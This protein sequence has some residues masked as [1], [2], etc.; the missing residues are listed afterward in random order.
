DAIDGSP[1]LDLKPWVMEFGPR[2]PLRQPGWI[3][4]LMQSY[5]D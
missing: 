4:E 1:V 3:T 5:W 2:G